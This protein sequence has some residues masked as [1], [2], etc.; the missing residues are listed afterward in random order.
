MKDNKDI[1]LEFLSKN[2]NQEYN[3]RGLKEELFPA[4]NEDIVKDLLYQIIKY[5]SNL[6]NVFNETNLG[7]LFVQYTGLVDSFLL[8]GGFTKIETD[9]KIEGGILQQKESL[10]IENLELENANM[11]YQESIREKEEQIRNLNK[12][13][14]RLNNWDIRFR[15]FIAIITFII[16]FIINFILNR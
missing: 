9:L 6:L 13:N 7:V 16:G 3:Q 5:K 15:W 14:L 12:D 2:R 8:N 11:K 10:E 1:I 4:L